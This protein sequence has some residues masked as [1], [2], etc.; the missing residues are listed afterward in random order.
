MFG[1]ARCVPARKPYNVY[2]YKIIYTCI[3]NYQ[4]S[5]KNVRF[6]KESRPVKCKAF[7]IQLHLPFEYSCR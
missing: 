5:L 7:K 3:I 4:P 2:F 1:G 6:L